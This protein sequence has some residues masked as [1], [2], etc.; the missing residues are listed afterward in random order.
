MAEATGLRAGWA[1]DLTVNQDDGSPWDLSIKANQDRAR[2]LQRGADARLARAKKLLAE[3][4]ND[5]AKKGTG[6]TPVSSEQS[7][8]VSPK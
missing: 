7:S 5:E 3:A 8:S 2:K 6:A 1:L 4:A